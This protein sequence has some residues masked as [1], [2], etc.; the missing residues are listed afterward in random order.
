[1]V[2]GILASF[3]DFMPLSLMDIK[4]SKSKSMLQV[5]F[6]EP[7]FTLP[8]RSKQVLVIDGA[9]TGGTTLVNAQEYLTKLS[10]QIKFRFAVLIQCVTSHFT[11]D[12]YAFLE[13]GII[14]P[15]PWHGLCS[16]AYLAPSEP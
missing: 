3:L 2:G 8:K 9:T 10:P 5:E 15:L 7:N 14:L 6:K 11:C 4:Y 1:M 12:Y 16:K 13:S